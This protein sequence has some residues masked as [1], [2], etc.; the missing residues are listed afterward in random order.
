MTQNIVW[1]ILIKVHKKSLCRIWSDMQP[2]YSLLQSVEIPLHT[3]DINDDCPK[4]VT[5]KLD[6]ESVHFYTRVLPPYHARMMLGWF[7]L[8]FSVFHSSVFYYATL[9]SDMHWLSKIGQMCFFIMFYTPFYAIGLFNIFGVSY[10]IMVSHSMLTFKY[11]VLYIFGETNQLKI[12]SKPQVELAFRGTRLNEVEV[13]D[14]VVSSERREIFFGSSFSYEA[15][16]YLNAEIQRF[17][18]SWENVVDL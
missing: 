8:P 17:Y 9:N 4:E 16:E 13:L 1:F 2:R 5:R 18:S 11:S 3:I 15:R 14:I 7:W 12:V 6:G 10:H